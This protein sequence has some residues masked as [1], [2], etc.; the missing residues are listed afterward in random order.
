MFIFEFK[1]GF[2]PLNLSSCYLNSN[3]RHFLSNFSVHS[4]ETKS[5]LPQIQIACLRVSCNAVST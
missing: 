4:F 2:K 5:P 3:G 1:Y